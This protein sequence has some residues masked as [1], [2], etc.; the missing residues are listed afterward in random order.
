MKDL[1]ISF[2]S[3]TASMDLNMRGKVSDLIRNSSANNAP[4]LKQ[5]ERVYVFDNNGLVRPSA[6]PKRG[7]KGTVVSVQTPIGERTSYDGD[8][9]VRWDGQGSVSRV[10]SNFVKKASKRVANLD[11][12]IMMG[13][14]ASLQAWASQESELVHKSTKDL[15][16]VRLS[17]DGSFDV[18]RLFDDDGNPLKV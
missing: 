7:S 14:N 6:L 17:E 10:A 4:S 8:V 12:F 5:G 11:D 16:K 15:W 3:R 13:S 2:G 18:E 1:D 9:F